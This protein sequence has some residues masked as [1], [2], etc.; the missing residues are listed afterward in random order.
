MKFTVEAKKR[1]ILYLLE[2]IQ[3]GEP[4]LTKV[5]SETFEVNQSTV[6]DYL[7]ELLDEGVIRKIK[8]GQYELVQK[9]HTYR[10]KRSEGE[11]EFDDAVYEHCMTPY[12]SFL[13][14]NVR[15]IWS[16]TFSEMINNVIDHSDAEMSNIIVIQDYLKTTV[17]MQDDGVGIFNKIQKFFNLSTP[18]DAISELFKGKLTTDSK[19]HSG[20]GIFFSSKMMDS[21]IIVSEGKVF[22]NNIYDDNQILDYKNAKKGTIVIMSL[23]NYSNKQAKEIFDMYASVDGGFVKTVLPIKNIFDTDPVSRS[24]AKRLC[25]R[26]DK[27]E[28]VKV[29]F[30][31]VEW[32]GQGF[33][34]QM[35]VVYAN[36]HKE[37]NLIPVN[38]NEDVKKMYNHVMTEK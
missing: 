25:N 27:F 13:P 1:I 24:Q 26:L 20:E 23:S 9:E 3:Q 35:F 14:N 17:I 30:A 6:H 37:V 34:H 38:M 8:R 18:E 33:A 28:D 15:R 4:S 10:L 22:C 36:E 31:G 7:K 29:D 21:F 32:M 19:N 2:K 11:L 12:V 16:Y 5:V